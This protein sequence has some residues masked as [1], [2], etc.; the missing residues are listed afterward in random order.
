MYV[1]AALPCC[2]A[3]ESG[4]RTKHYQL[5]HGSLGCYMSHLQLYQ[6]ILR[7]GQCAWD[8]HGA[9]GGWCRWAHTCHWAALLLGAACK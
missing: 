6:H 8:A 1:L 3:D 9:A 2:A 5:T 4:Y 7:S